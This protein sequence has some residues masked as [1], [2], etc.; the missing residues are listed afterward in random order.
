MSRFSPASVTLTVM[1]VI[2]DTT[3]VVPH[4]VDVELSGLVLIG[5]KSLPVSAE[6]LQPAAP[7][8]RVRTFGLIGEVKVVRR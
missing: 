5:T 4:H 8:I 7:R 3:I 2:G 6:E 1:Q